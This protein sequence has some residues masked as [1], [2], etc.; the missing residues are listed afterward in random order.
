MRKLPPSLFYLLLLY[1]FSLLVNPL[2]SLVLRTALGLI[3]KIFVSKE[4]LLASAESEGSP[5]KRATH[6][7][8]R[9]LIV[10]RGA[11]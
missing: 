11:P 6:N 3:G 10:A 8:S 1:I 9:C 5:Q 7:L 2:C 4:I